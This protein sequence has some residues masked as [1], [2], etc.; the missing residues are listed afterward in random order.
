MKIMIQSIR[1]RLIDQELLRCVRIHNERRGSSFSLRSL[2]Y[3]LG[4]RVNSIAFF[5]IPTDMTH[6]QMT[7]GCGRQIE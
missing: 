6:V 2:D 3:R 4:T 1:L 7:R 5:E